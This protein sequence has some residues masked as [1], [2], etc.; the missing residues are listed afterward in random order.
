MLILVGDMKTC[1][2]EVLCVVTNSQIDEFLKF[3][4]FFVIL[5]VLAI[6]AKFLYQIGYSVNEL[7][8]ISVSDISEEDIP[9]SYFDYDKLKLKEMFSIGDIDAPV[10]LI[11]F[12][13]FECPYCYKFYK[14]NYKKLKDN[15]I[16]KGL[17]KFYFSNYPLQNHSNGFILS[18]IFLILKDEYDSHAFFTKYY[19]F[20]KDLDLDKDFVSK[21]SKEFDVE[22][23]ELLEDK[24]IDNLLYEDMENGFF[25]N[26]TGTPTFLVNDMKSS[27]A[28]S[29]DKLEQLILKELSYAEMKVDYNFIRQNINND[30][31]V[32]L[33][34]R[35]L[36]EFSH[37]SIPG[38]VNIDILNETEFKI[39]SL[40]LDRNK[41]LVVF[42][43][44]GK[45]AKVAI[46]NLQSMNFKNIKLYHEGYDEYSEK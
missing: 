21:I 10:S 14:E 7:K 15:Y 44:S 24:K 11:L 22:L 8:D 34:V 25:A 2:R 23:K 3:V 37:G 1:V 18:K 16:D 45:R 13:D 5:V 41:E 29:F 31:V 19:D 26:V 33:D 39:D 4:V 35:T 20:V 30:E 28:I 40:D 12:S 36:E 17:V 42:C 6:Q 27:G 46:E 32:L 9:E 38:S 43:K